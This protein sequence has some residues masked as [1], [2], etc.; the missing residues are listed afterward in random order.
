MEDNKDKLDVLDI[1]S[2]KGWYKQEFSISNA[3]NHLN[4]SENFCNKRK[5][6]YIANYVILIDQMNNF[7]IL[8]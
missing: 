4:N 5:A 1:L 2:N 6:K 8:Y 7:I 3:F